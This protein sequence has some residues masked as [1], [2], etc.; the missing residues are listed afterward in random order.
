MPQVPTKPTDKYFYFL[1]FCI[2]IT[3][4]TGYWL[5]SRCHPHCLTN[6][7]VPAMMAHN[8]CGRQPQHTVMTSQPPTNHTHH[9]DAQTQP[10]HARVQ[11]GAYGVH[12]PSAANCCDRGAAGLCKRRSTLIP[13][14][15]SG[16]GIVSDGRVHEVAR[17]AARL[18]PPVSYKGCYENVK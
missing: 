16:K 7:P 10:E 15:G 18:Q 2:L 11:Q 5:Q 17:V 6:A 1:L 13:M 8:D 9:S 3:T 4:I 12:P 14:G